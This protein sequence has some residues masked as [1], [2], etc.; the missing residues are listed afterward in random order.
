MIAKTGDAYGRHIAPSSV[1]QMNT[2][3]RWP[4]AGAGSARKA[5]RSFAA[6][7]ASGLVYRR[8]QNRRAFEGKAAPTQEMRD[9]SDNIHPT[10]QKVVLLSP[11][12]CNSLRS[13]DSGWWP[14]DDL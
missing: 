9:S 8:C 3:G 7:T 10:A 14:G 2:W 12:D 4:S 11:L 6:Q 13:L 1:L 5:L